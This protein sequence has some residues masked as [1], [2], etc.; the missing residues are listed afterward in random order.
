MKK[1]GQLAFTLALAAVMA[2]GAVALSSPPAEAQY[3]V[4]CPN[5]ICPSNLF[6][7]TQDGSCQHLVNGCLHDCQQYKKQNPGWRFISRCRV[8]S[9]NP[10]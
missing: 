6:G 8:T 4:A 9:C 1:V 2:L 5:V 3:G 7:W 10:L